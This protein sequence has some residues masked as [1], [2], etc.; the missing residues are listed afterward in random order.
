MDY[1]GQ[2]DH[3]IETQFGKIFPEGLIFGY[4]ATCAN[5]EYKIV[6]GLTLS[7]FSETRAAVSHKELLEERDGVRHLFK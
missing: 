2:V 1:C 4:P 7:D 6:Q 5:G 3:C